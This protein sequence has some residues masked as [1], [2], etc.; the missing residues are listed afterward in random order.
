MLNS[1]HIVDGTS[2]VKEAARLVGGD[3]GMSIG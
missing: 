2:L 3:G 1:I